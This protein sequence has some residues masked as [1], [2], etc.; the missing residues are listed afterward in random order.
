[1]KSGLIN[2][3]NSEKEAVFISFAAANAMTIL[4]MAGHDFS[5]MNLSKISIPGADLSYGMFKKTNFSGA[6]LRG[7]NFTQACLEDAQFIKANMSEIQFGQM[8]NLDLDEK[9]YCIAY[10]PDANSLIASTL[11]D[12]IIFE[13]FGVQRQDFVEVKRLKGHAGCIK[14]CSF[15]ADGVF[16]ITG[17]EDRTIRIWNYETK[18]FICVLRGHTSSVVNCQF[19]HDRTQIISVEKDG[20]V[21]KWNYHSDKWHLAFK[22][23]LEGTANCGFVMNDE[24]LIFV[25][26]KNRELNLYNA[27]DGK[28]LQRLQ[29]KTHIDIVNNYKFSSD[30]KQIVTKNH[31]VRKNNNY[32]FTYHGPNIKITDY[33]RS[34]EIKYI[35]PEIKPDRENYALDKWTYD[36]FMEKLNHIQ[37]SLIIWYSDQIILLN[38]ECSV[39]HNSV[40]GKHESSVSLLGDNFS[41]NPIETGQIAV[42]SKLM[43]RISC[44]SLLSKKKTLCTHKHGVNRLGINLQHANIDYSYGLSDEN[45]LM[46]KQKGDYTCFTKDQIRELI[47]GD[48]NQNFAHVT[49]INLHKTGR[50]WNHLNAIGKNAT[51]GKS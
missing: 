13:K 29:N 6:E 45:I 11:G 30:G 14:T 28:H 51:M 24:H 47:L 22:L 50:E 16:M 36:S 20:Q 38:E 44:E 32:H 25:E 7:V 9:V 31:I 23:S 21:L 12:I 5:E 15:S 40:T 46:F 10:S 17:G 49:E 3:Q 33:I 39:F 18:E 26:T 42:F 19:N 27:T 2:S 8:L 48:I 41:I 37:N 4:N 1:M 34:H 35:A 43:K